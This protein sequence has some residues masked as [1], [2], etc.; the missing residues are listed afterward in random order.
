MN[1]TEM[2]TQQR[3]DILAARIERLTQVQLHTI[4]KL[5]KYRGSWSSMKAARRK[6]VLVEAVKAGLVKLEVLETAVAQ[7]CGIQKP[8]ET[9]T[10]EVITKEPNIDEVA[11]RV[12]YKLEPVI[13]NKVRSEV[14]NSVDR[15]FGSYANKA[16]SLIRDKMA[17]AIKKLDQARPVV[18]KQKG[19]PDVKMKGVLPEEFDRI[20][21]LAASRK[22]VMLVG[23]SGC[24][25]TYIAERVAEALGMTFSS[26][27]CSAGMSES[28]V[29]G[30]L[31]PTGAGGKFEFKASEYLQRYEEG[32]L[33]L[34]DEMDN[35]DPNMLV[36]LNQSLA[37]D[38]F[39]IPQ[40]YT[41]PMAKKHKDFV[42]IAATNTFGNG[43]DM[44]YVG[45]NQLD[46]ATL[47]R[48]RS[49]LVM[50]DY[51]K[52]VEEALVDPQVL[53]WGLHIRKR[54][55]E[56]KLRR[57]MSTRV[58]LDFTDLKREQGWEKE[59]WERSYFADWSAD[60]KRKTVI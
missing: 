29:T 3:T 12:A 54:I 10:T 40:R 8:T 41:K 6:L 43:A 42:C 58:M 24:G 20:L 51:S 56:L 55:T 26:V 31:L 15:V 16:N 14:S 57:I 34:M 49:G 38:K 45:R 59:Q 46:A 25:K 2:T 17:E 23:P 53:E 5:I 1:S 28:F 50:M 39:F 48:F 9:T 47:D 33:H 21:E 44:Q 52:R 22:N 18:V 19:K 7:V 32:G 27:S 60:E 4:F 30:W 13:D 11:G 37:N 36:Y 35:A